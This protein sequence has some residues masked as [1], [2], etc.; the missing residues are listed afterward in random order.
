[1]LFYLVA[2][3]C[4]LAALGWRFATY[5]RGGAL[6]LITVAGLAP[7]A[8]R[9]DLFPIPAGGSLFLV[10]AVGLA[11]LHTQLAR[12]RER[13]L[14][15]I[16]ITSLPVLYL[17][18]LAALA[19]FFLGSGLFQPDPTNGVIKGASV[20][21]KGGLPVL[22]LVLFGRFDGEE[23]TRSVIAAI[24]AASI[25]TALAVLSN[26]QA[27]LTARAS[28]SEGAS[29]ITVA[30]AIGIGAGAAIVF[31]MLAPSPL[32]LLK[33]AGAA[34][35]AL[36]LLGVTMLTGSRGPLLAA[37]VSGLA[38]SLLLPSR[39]FSAGVRLRRTLALAAAAGLTLA[40]ISPW[41]SAFGG[42][43]RI[44][45]TV[46]T[47]GRN[48][49]ELQRIDLWQRTVEAL[50][51][52]VLTGSGAATFGQMA[53][54]R[55]QYPHNL[56]LELAYEGGPLGILLGGMLLGI[57]AIAILRRARCG[58]LSPHEVALVAAWS[59]IVLND[60]VSGTVQHSS[61]LYAGGALL[62]LLPGAASRTEPDVT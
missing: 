52:V 25:L 39:P 31:A 54:G 37:V 47:L 59:V 26:T 57:P 32:G 3:G 4:A 44:T 43:E 51:D 5:P 62:T 8:I 48:R 56:E 45:T 38:A 35:L 30:R 21:L 1:M 60:Q 55:S 16:A 41:L 42:F 29:P 13:P 36:A 50:P 34:L 58:R 2:L 10:G 9:W 20:L 27:L 15:R 6:A 61:A 33:R 19:V 18:C 24:L 46:G 11:I 17:G 14:A 12:I 23:D 40:L 53:N 49:T 7:G 28:T 22:A